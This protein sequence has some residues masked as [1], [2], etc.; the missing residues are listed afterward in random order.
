MNKQEEK[1]HRIGASFPAA[2]ASQLIGKPCYK[3][4]GK[5][6][7]VFSGTRWFASCMVIFMT[8]R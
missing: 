5:V 3:K 4:S 1:F 8:L 7:M 2:Q 6:F